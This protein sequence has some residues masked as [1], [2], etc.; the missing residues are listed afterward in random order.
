MWIEYDLRFE[1]EVKEIGL[2]NSAHV[3]SIQVEQHGGGYGK[4][5]ELY[6]DGH[7][8]KCIFIINDE[9]I[10]SKVWIAL[11]N[12]LAGVPSSVAGIGFIRP[13]QRPFGNA[14]TLIPSAYPGM[15][16]GGGSV[17]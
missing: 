13:L 4:A 10:F 14:S 17:E 5:I 7:D 2:F 1:N 16:L 11:L 6:Y 15:P 12:A 9:D 8:A 3:K